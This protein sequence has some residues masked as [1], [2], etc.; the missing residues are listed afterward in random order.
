MI[1]V[2]G[3]APHS[4]SLRIW[5]RILVML[6]FFCEYELISSNLASKQN[7]KSHQLRQLH[8]Y[9]EGGWAHVIFY[10]AYYTLEVETQ[11]RLFSWSCFP[12]HSGF[13]WKTI[14]NHIPT[15]A[16]HMGN[17]SS[18]TGHNELQIFT[19]ITWVLLYWFIHSLHTDRYIWGEW[20]LVFTITLTWNSYSLFL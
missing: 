6:D 16:N 5:I 1:G 8:W 7:T 20:L 11:T 9:W 17:F 15:S 10:L 2:S 18:L 13:W 12:C 14:P 19:Y 3:R 4:Q